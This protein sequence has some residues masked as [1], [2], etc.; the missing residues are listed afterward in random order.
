MAELWAAFH[1]ARKVLA[2]GALAALFAVEADAGAAARRAMVALLAV[3]TLLVDAP[4]DW[5]RRRG[6]MR[7]YG[8]CLFHAVNGDGGEL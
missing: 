2:L 5:M 6:I 3:R 4:L 8:S 1:G 7:C